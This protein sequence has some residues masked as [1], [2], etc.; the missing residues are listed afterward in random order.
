MDVRDLFIFPFQGVQALAERFLRSAILRFT[1]VLI[2]TILP[3][4]IP[5]N[6]LG[7]R[8]QLSPN[9]QKYDLC[10]HIY[11]HSTGILTCFPFFILQVM[12]LIR[13]NLPLTDLHCQG[14]LALSVTEILTLL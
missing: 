4:L 3:R 2:I 11:L 13:T 14:T 6:I 1:R 10:C 7:K 5:I 9:S 12:E 8:Y